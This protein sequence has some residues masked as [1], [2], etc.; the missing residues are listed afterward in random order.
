M[1]VV[2]L[3]T[4]GRAIRAEG[5]PDSNPSMKMNSQLTKQLFTHYSNRF[6]G[7]PIMLNTLKDTKRDS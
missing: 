2:E 4:I 5:V 1:I 7:R 3:L 6:D